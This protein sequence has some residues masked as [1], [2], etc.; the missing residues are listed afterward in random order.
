MLHSSP[1]TVQVP[2]SFSLPF[3]SIIVPTLNSGLHLDRC[4]KSIATQDYPH[5][6]IELIVADGGSTDETL[7]IAQRYATL[8]VQNQLKT[9]EA[10]KA[11]GLKVATGE[12]IAFIDS[13]NILPQTDWLKKMVVPFQDPLITGCEPI[14]FHYDRTDSAITRYCA[15][16]GMNDP[17]CLFLGNYD[18]FNHIT[19]RWT[20][21]NLK[22]QECVGYTQ[23]TL[24]GSSLPTIGANG[25][26]YRRGVLQTFLDQ[27]YFFDIDV[28]AE[29]AH[30]GAICFAKVHVSIGHIFTTTWA[31]FTK[32]QHRR[33]TDYLYYSNKQRR[34][35]EWSQFSRGSVC[36]A[37]EAPTGARRAFRGDLP[38]SLGALPIGRRLPAP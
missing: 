29:L 13:D 30:R 15:M 22:T 5:D 6:H 10:G 24:Q 31:G 37:N 7:T 23:I 17:I 36:L 16:L 25:T 19:Q 26:M 38:K 28:I 18:R 21:I 33:V 4:L 27:D 12:V 34:N 1:S 2:S 3:L 9:G 11:A 35:Y 8:I 20:E 32:K 14:A